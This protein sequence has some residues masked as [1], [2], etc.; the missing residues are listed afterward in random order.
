MTEVNNDVKTSVVCSVVGK[1]KQDA[2]AKYQKEE[3]AH[4]S[5][6]HNHGGYIDLII[7]WTLRLLF[8]AEM[9]WQDMFVVLVISLAVVIVV[10]VSVLSCACAQSFS[11]ASTRFLF[12]NSWL[13]SFLLFACIADSDELQSAS[14]MLYCL[15]DGV[16]WSVS[17]CMQT[18]HSGN[19]QAWWK[20]LD[21]MKG[22]WKRW[23]A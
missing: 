3:K 7:L 4:W 8:T 21:K 18:Q 20:S 19:W 22:L 16:Y 6:E 13:V 23:Q 11:V 14:N 10:K 12:C 1:N 2:M 17:A 5:V 15:S 9:T